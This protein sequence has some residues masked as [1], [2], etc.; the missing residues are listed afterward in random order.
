MKKSAIN[1]Q[2]EASKCFNPYTL[3]D[4]LIRTKEGFV[5][6][7]RNRLLNDKN[8]LR[9]FYIILNKD[10]HWDY[11]FP[12]TSTIFF[13]IED[14]RIEGGVYEMNIGP[15]SQ[16]VIAISRERAKETNYNAYAYEPQDIEAIIDCIK[17]A[18]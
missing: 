2:T 17:A 6:V 12:D 10:Y 13:R 8:E 4:F 11:Q 7:D 16:K 9:L 1:E 18:K 5:V 15:R 14:G 3:K